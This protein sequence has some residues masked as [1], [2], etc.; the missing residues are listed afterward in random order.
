MYNSAHSLKCLKFQVIMVFITVHS[1]NE[2]KNKLNKH[3]LFVHAFGIC[4][5]PYISIFLSNFSNFPNF[6]KLY[7]I[8][9][10]LHFL[11]TRSQRDRCPPA[12]KI[13]QHL[14]HRCRSDVRR[15]YKRNTKIIFEITEITQ[16]YLYCCQK[17]LYAVIY[18][19]VSC[20]IADIISWWFCLTIN[21]QVSWRFIVKPLEFTRLE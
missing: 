12:Y 15:P 8:Y 2:I 11:R 7:C 21:S 3:I 5:Q 18:K 20:Y 16:I 9:L 1:A 10:F 6:A 4:L 13:V 17:V 14:H 19:H